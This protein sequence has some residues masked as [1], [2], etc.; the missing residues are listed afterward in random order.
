MIVV[1]TSVWIDVL[2]GNSTRQ[3]EICVELIE[4]GQPVGLTDVVFGE[5][6]QGL[7]DDGEA[8]E[9]ARHLRA[10]PI[11]GLEGL[12]DFEFAASLY[13][14]ARVAGIT[15]RKT[16]DCLIAVPCIRAGAPL[17]HADRDFDLLASCSELK[18]WR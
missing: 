8:D 9:V 4:T 15:I 10:Y 13:R 7:R 16:L 1:D 11:L 18:I 12:S 17:L 14:Q 3:S 5:I 2:N 6:L